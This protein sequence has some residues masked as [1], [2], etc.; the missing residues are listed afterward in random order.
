MQQTIIFILIF[1]VSIVPVDYSSGDRLIPEQVTFTRKVFNKNNPTQLFKLFVSY[2]L[3]DGT[4]EEERHEINLGIQKL[5]TQ[6]IA[7]FKEEMKKVQG[8]SSEITYGIFNFDYLV[9]YHSN[10]MVSVQFQKDVDFGERYGKKSYILTFNYNLSAKRGVNPQTIF[11][12]EGNVAKE[13][14]QLIKAKAQV[15][16]FKP[17]PKRVFDKFTLTNEHLVFYFDETNSN[18]EE[19]NEVFLD[20]SEVQ[21]L[22]ADKSDFLVLE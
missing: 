15:N 9:T 19:I 7:D 14:Y 8:K 21:H 22:L 16:D 1:L 4:N 6:A 13:V 5:M 3:A 11:S 18:K 2:P 10:Q 12:S 17:D 20:W